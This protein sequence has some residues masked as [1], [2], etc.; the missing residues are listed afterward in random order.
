M[1]PSIHGFKRKENKTH[2]KLLKP[3]NEK[4]NKFNSEKSG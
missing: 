3:E 1:N 2:K 4:K